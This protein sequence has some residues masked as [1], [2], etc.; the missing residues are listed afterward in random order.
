MK[1]KSHALGALTAHGTDGRRHLLHRRR[2]LRAALDTLFQRL[3]VLCGGV[4]TALFNHRAGLVDNWLRH[5]QDVRDL[6]E[7][8]LSTLPP[9]HRV[10]ALV[11]LNVL[12]QARNVCRTTVVQDAWQRAQPLTVHGW[13]YGLKDGL[14]RDLGMNVSRADDL[15]PR[16]AAALEALAS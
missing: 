8:F 2:A 14:I 9:E 7:A 6:H 12:E 13:I 16:Y 11:E 10:N 3:D 4:R 1:I 15:M 5:V